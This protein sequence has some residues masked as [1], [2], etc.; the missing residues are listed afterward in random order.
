MSSKS[1]KQID[2]RTKTYKKIRGVFILCVIGGMVLFMF[3]I[4]GKNKSENTLSETVANAVEGE[5]G[6][7]STISEASLEKVFEIS[8]LSTA[9]YTYNAIA[10]AYNEDGVTVKYYV[11]YEGK[12]KAG[13][14]FSKIVIDIDEKEKIITITIPD[15][16]I[17]DKIVNPGTLEYIFKDKK[18]ETE[19]VHQEAFKICEEDLAERTDAEEDL[20]VLAKKNALAVVEA[21]VAPWVEQIDDGYEVKIQ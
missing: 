2:E 3:L 5:E 18:S 11:A 14:D 17:T 15:V 13:I 7:I 10:K 9:D 4:R 20:I 6:K 19:T 8:E 1:I 12:V 16:E 21:L